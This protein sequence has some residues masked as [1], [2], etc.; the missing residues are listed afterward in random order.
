MKSTGVSRRQRS[1]AGRRQWGRA[2]QPERRDPYELDAKPAEPAACPQCGAIY[3]DGRWQWGPPTTVAR[4]QLC[5]A[6]RRI[7][8][9]L[10]AGVLTLGGSVLRA[11]KA[12]IIQLARHREAAEKAE[13]P[14]NRIIAIDEQDDTIVITTTD[15]HLPRRIG[16]ALKR[17]HRGHLELSYDEDAYFVRATWRSDAKTRRRSPA[18]TPRL[19][20][21]GRDRGD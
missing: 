4:A 12:E 9:G 6:C 16:E 14:L 17:A 15:I 5:A 11:K 20:V 19:D 2:Q 7:N 1:G 10:P 21:A 3:R 8:D 13:H 18:N